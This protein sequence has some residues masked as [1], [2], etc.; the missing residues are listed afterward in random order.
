MAANC[1]NPAEPA[2]LVWVLCRAPT[3]TVFAT[4]MEKTPVFA[5]SKNSD[6]NPFLRIMVADALRSLSIYEKFATP[7]IC[8]YFHYGL[9]CFLLLAENM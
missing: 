1:L 2:V 3:L 8:Y 5:F 4:S 7:N 6:L 9:V